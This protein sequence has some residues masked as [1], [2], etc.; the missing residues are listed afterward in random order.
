[1]YAMINPGWSV[2][3]NT[4]T[5]FQIQCVS[6]KVPLRNHSN[7]VK[8]ARYYAS[9]NLKWRLKRTSQKKTLRIAS[10]ELA[11][12]NQSMCSDFLFRTSAMHLTNIAAFN[13]MM[14]RVYLLVAQFW[15][16]YECED[17]NSFKISILRMCTFYAHIWPGTSRSYQHGGGGGGGGAS[18]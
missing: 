14:Y 18:L 8:C 6:K 15:C 16:I 12:N 5:T 3:C 9:G 13:C 7:V 10:F 11:L 2:I 17:S 4:L 1:M